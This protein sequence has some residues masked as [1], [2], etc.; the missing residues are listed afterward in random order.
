MDL[1]ETLRDPFGAAVVA[2]CCTAAYIHF[3]AKMNNEGK[4]ELSS[5]TK[6]S[7]L[8]AILVYFIVSGGVGAKENISVDPY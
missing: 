3:K 2:A 7:I 1:N 5:Y 4:L 8:N 6:P